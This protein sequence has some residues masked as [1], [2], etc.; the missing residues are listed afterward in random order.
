MTNK[1]YTMQN[2]NSALKR[3]ANK[4]KQQYTCLDQ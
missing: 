1:K 4:N 2:I 3:K